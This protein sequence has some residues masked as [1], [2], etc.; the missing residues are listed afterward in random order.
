MLVDCGVFIVL[1]GKII[2]DELLYLLYNSYQNRLRGRV[3]F[4]QAIETKHIGF[5]QHL[6]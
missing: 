5:I 6:G 2:K 4:V 1:K 3:L